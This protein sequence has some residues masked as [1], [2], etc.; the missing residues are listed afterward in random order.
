MT[1]DDFRT[2][3]TAGTGRRERLARLCQRSGVLSVL[4]GMR[5]LLRNDVRILAYHRVLASTDPAGFTFDAELIS[6]SAAAFRAQMRLVK[7]H[8]HP[9]RFDELLAYI[10]SGH[11]LPRKSVLVTFDDGYDDNYRIA[12]PILRELDMSAMFFVSTGHIDTGL[13]YVYDWLA[14]MICA[15]PSGE[16]ALPELD[17][18]V[19]VSESLPS[20]RKLVARVLDRLKV[21]DAERQEALIARLEGELDMPRAKGHAD[22]RPMSW[23]QLREMQRGGM[24]VGSHG[25]HHRM[26][27]KLPKVQIDKELSG[28]RQVLQH[29][30]GVPIQVLSYPVGGLDAYDDAVIESARTAG[31]RMACSYISG[32]SMIHPSARFAMPRLPVE[33]QMDIAWFE[34]MLAVPEVFSYTSRRRTR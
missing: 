22:C 29:E 11:A 33:R 13:P 26:L 5:R 6:A 17:M 19:Q 12:W 7:R 20:R 3:G 34:A 8:F 4:A 9:L 28:S 23:Q 14:H 16:L 15:M 31:Y 1:S 10:D 24:E 27:A 21:L 18:R 30:L 25:V 2:A 32:T